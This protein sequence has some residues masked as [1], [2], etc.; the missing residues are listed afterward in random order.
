MMF[1]KKPIIIEG[2]RW[3]GFNFQEVQKFIGDKA[4]HNP[5]NTLT[6]STLEGNHLA[7]IGDY[8][9]QGVKGEFYP[10]K[11]AIFKRTYDDYQEEVTD[12]SSQS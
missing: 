4:T 11:S 3:N 10:C 9:T 5:D 2:I 7:M 8:I 6:I 12:S 1:R